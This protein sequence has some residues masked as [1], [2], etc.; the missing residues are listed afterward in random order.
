MGKWLS[1]TH[2][3][4]ASFEAM[5]H[6]KA[7]EQ[8]RGD[9]EWQEFLKQ[10]RLNSPAL[11]ATISQVF[12]NFALH[13]VPFAFEKLHITEKPID[14]TAKV[15]QNYSRHLKDGWWSMMKKPIS[16]Q[17]L[18]ENFG[19]QSQV[20][21]SSKKCLMLLLNKVE[22]RGDTQGAMAS[23]IKSM[24]PLYGCLL[25]DSLFLDHVY[26]SL[27]VKIIAYLH[28]EPNPRMQNFAEVISGSYF[29]GKGIKNFPGEDPSLWLLDSQIK[30]DAARLFCHLYAHLSLYDFSAANEDIFANIYEEIIER[31]NRRKIG[32]YYTPNWLVE[33]VLDE[34]ISLWQS[35]GNHKE[36]IPKICDPACGSGAFLRYAL[37]GLN[38]KEVPLKT[39]L[40][41]VVGMDIN[42]IA[43]M[44]AKAN[45]IIAL[46]DSIRGT[47]SEIVLPVYLMDSLQSPLFIDSK[48]DKCDI[49]VGNPPWAVMR[50]LERCYQDFLKE[51]ALKYRLLN[52]KDVHL[53][54]Q[55]ELATLFFCKCAD[56]YLKEGG[57]IAFVMPH[58]VLSDTA[59]HANFRKFRNPTMRLHKVIDLEAVKPLFK[60][61]ACVLIA[62]RDGETKYPVP[63]EKYEGHLDERNP[64]LSEALKILQV[65]K[66]NYIPQD[67]SREVSDYYEM[68]K[69]GASI[70]PRSF[71]FVDI[72]SRNGGRLKVITTSDIYQMAKEPW[73]VKIEGCVEEE[74]LFSTIL[75]WE[76]IP[77]GYLKLRAVIL[78]VEESHSGYKLLDLV[79][80][81]RKGA[82]GI[83]QWF[84]M[85]E[86][87]WRE[88]R[89]PKSKKRFA[90][91][92]DRLNYN[93]LLTTQNWA[94]RYV[95]L[96]SATGTNLVSCVVDRR[97]LETFSV[98]VRPKGF[99]AD[100]KTWFYETDV[101][102]EA[103]Y[104][105]AILNSEVINQK[106]KPLQPRGLFGAR[107]IHR[108][109][110]RFAI[111]QFNGQNE[112]HIE[113]AKMGQMA[114]EK[115][116]SLRLNLKGNVRAQVRERLNKEINEI[117]QLVLQLLGG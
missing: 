19:M 104:L 17:L 58:S 74:F 39:L 78:P 42:P 70:F 71:Y 50:S 48:V 94:K 51:E 75:A 116:K 52:G 53:F 32:E 61:P 28:L 72:L 18:C 3:G 2:E 10:K 33:L 103:H 91:L 35:F 57:I 85:A 97:S 44:M 79:S 8:L 65:T 23:W 89:T 101:E 4:L 7:V 15:V 1:R 11:R 100:V 34:A 5:I 6:P 84:E 21:Q 38:K 92:L 27:L 54:T 45:C 113:L 60:M 112:L 77:F 107:A 102:M 30:D 90:S 95:V 43:V 114:Y 106:I 73:Q 82:L 49:L 64:K 47:N 37:L 105:S 31:R 110:L 63:V 24:M 36:E 69:V 12:G 46:G 81:R 66:H 96:Y 68:F 83:T 16:A 115:A 29:E 13:Y 67:S 26:L 62:V 99:V 86:K 76:I 20:F 117:N 93:A 111:P 14:S 55:M 9:K 41:K 40:E 88:R 98:D 25:Q 56:L 22:R 109:P 108:R 80:L 59:Q 87:I